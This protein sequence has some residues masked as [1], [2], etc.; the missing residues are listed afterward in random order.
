MPK[1]LLAFL[2]LA[3]CLAC[4]GP[5]TA[6]DPAPQLT[7]AA[8]D[9]ADRWEEAMQTF[10]KADSANPPPKGGIVFFG[11]S[12]F[13]R[14]DLEKSFPG[15]GLINRGFGGSQMSDA[16][17]YLDRAVLPLEPR[18]IFVYEGDND[19]GSGKTPEI[20]EADYRTFV[21]KARAALPEVKIVFVAIK[22]SIRRWE[23][24]DKAREAN[25]KVKAITETDDRL[26]Y[27]D[28]DTPLLDSNGQPR[29]DLFVEDD[30]HLNDAGYEIW[31]ELIRPYLN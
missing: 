12:S 2:I 29:A 22:P 5:E 14:W 11:S 18:T 13:R 15:M 19:V 6:G 28:V 16:I 20:V 3:L 7:T 24:I 1:S 10:E 26:E 21:E 9:D 25:A 31:T 30:L 27:I 8:A 23:L 4:G 17:R